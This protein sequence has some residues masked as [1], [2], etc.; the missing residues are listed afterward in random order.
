MAVQ[1]KDITEA[2]LHETKGVSVAANNSFLKANGGVGVWA[3]DEDFID[4]DIANISTLTSYNLIMPH[5]GTLIKMFSV[6]D[7]A[8]ATANAT[9]QLSIAG[10]NVTNGL[11]TITQAGSAA[12]DIDSATPTALNTATQGQL[13]TVTVGGGATGTTRCH[14]SIIFLRTA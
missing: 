13:V 5:T 10:V 1:H 3:F 14:V 7:S 2:N 11:I 4:L 8:I 12:G 6:I 9:L